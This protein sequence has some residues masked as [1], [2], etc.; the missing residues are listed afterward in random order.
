MT[1]FPVHT[2]ES[3]PE[4]AKPALQQ[5]QSAFS[6]IPNIAGAMATSP[7]PDKDDDRQAW[8]SRRRGYQSIPC[9]RVR[10]RLL[11]VIDA[12]AASTITNYTGTITKPPLEASFEGH[13]S[14]G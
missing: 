8:M 2:I 4:R 11:E 5:L 12:V 3:A 7:T 1:N 6:M 13:A 14:H 9:G 10:Q